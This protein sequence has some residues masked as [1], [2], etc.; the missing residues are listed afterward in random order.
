MLQFNY[1]S[2]L[3]QSFQWQ[4]ENTLALN[5]KRKRHFLITVTSCF[6]TKTNIDCTVIAG[7]NK[8]TDL[9]HG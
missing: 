1:F 5:G 9:K 8:T 2:V 3:N 7:K 6:R 4:S